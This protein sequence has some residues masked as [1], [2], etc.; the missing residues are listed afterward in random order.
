[1]NEECRISAV[2]EDVVVMIMEETSPL[3]AKTVELGA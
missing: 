1:M 2:T 3:P